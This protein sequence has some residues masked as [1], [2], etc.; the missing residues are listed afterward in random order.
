MTFTHSW[1]AGLLI[2]WLNPIYMAM[3]NTYKSYPGEWLV[4]SNYRSV[5]P[6]SIIC[7]IYETNL[8]KAHLSFLSEALSISPHQ[9]GFL[10]RRS[11]L[12]NLLVFEEVVTRMM[13]EGHAVDLIYLDCAKAVPRFLLDWGLFQ[14]TFHRAPW[15][16]HSC[17]SFSWMTSQMP[18]KQWPCSLRLMS[19]WWLGGSR[20]WTCTVLL[21]LHAT[22]RRN[23]TYRSNLSN[24]T[25][26]S[27]NW[28]LRLFFSP[29]G[30]ATSSL[31]P[32]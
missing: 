18:S 12:S 6:D 25:F 13:D 22:G 16:A 23:W 9:H 11:C 15:L 10:P 21:L 31:H 24:A 5:R 27:Y 28:A 32:N 17:F 20:T 8:K 26:T 30:T 29:M 3:P 1:F 19:E 2:S 7:Q 14:C 4:A